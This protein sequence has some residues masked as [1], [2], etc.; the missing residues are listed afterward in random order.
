MDRFYH[1]YM[2]RQSNNSTR[3]VR[4]AVLITGGVIVLSATANYVNK[5]S[6]AGEQ[7]AIGFSDFGDLDFENGMF[8]GRVGLLFTNSGEV[9]LTVQE[10]NLGISVAGGEIATIEQTGIRRTIQTNRQPIKQSFDFSVPVWQ[11]GLNLLTGLITADNPLTVRIQGRVRVS[12]FWQKID[13][14][15]QYIPKKKENGKN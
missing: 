3:H 6:E 14:T 4:T 7:L 2:A 9:G 1:W 10:A 5:L 15:Y 11:A 8:T 12:G 13:D